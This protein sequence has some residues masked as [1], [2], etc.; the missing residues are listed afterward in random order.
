MAGEY[1]INLSN[2]SVL[3]TLYPL[4]TNGPD[5]RSTPRFIQQT[6]PAF[7]VTFLASGTG[8][9]LRDVITI[10]GIWDQ[11]FP[12]GV[13]FDISG[14]SVVGSPAVG[15]N[16]GTYA[17]VGVTTSSSPDQTHIE[18]SNGS[19]T[20][21]SPVDGNVVLNSFVLAGDVSYRF[22][23]GFQFDV[24]NS[25]PVVG[26]PLTGQ[27]DGTYTVDSFGSYVASNSTIIPVS[28]T[29]PGSGLPLGE[30]I[31][32]NVDTCS[33]LSLPGRGTLNYGEKVIE[34][35]VRLV[36]NFAANTPPNTN[37]NIGTNPSASPLVGQL[38]YNTTYGSEGFNVFTGTAWTSLNDIGTSSLV[39]NDPENSNADI[40]ITAAEA[41][42]PTGSPWAGT[43]EP[44]LV[45]WTETDPTDNTP[46]FRVLSSDGTERLR[47]E[48][49]STANAGYVST[50]NNLDVQGTG[51]SLIQGSLG[52]GGVTPGYTLDV[53]GT[54][55]IAGRVGI[56]QAPP[57]SGTPAG[58][59]IWLA[60]T[61]DIQANS[62]FLGSDGS[63]SDPTYSF[64]NEPTTG[65]FLDTGST[66]VF[67]VVGSNE[68]SISSSST[69][70]E[71]RVQVPSGSAVAPSMTFNNDTS[72]GT[73][74]A[75]S[76]TLAFA[77]GGSEALRINSNG[78][79]SVSLGSPTYDSFVTSDNDIPNKK[80]VD[81]TVSA[82]SSV[83]VNVT[84]DAMTGN[85]VMSSGGQFINPSAPT[86]SNDLTNKAYV[87][88]LVVSGTVWKAPINDPALV[89]FS[90]TEPVSPQTGAGYIATAAG[91]WTGSVAVV[92]GDYVYWDG[93]VWT[94][95]QNVT[96]GDRFIVAGESVVAENYL[97][98]LGFR[99][100]D[101]IEFT[102]TG[103][104]LTFDAYASWSFPSDAG[105]QVIDFG[106]AKVSGDATGLTTSS[107]Y[108][109][110]VSIAGTTYQISV[111]GANIA[112]YGGLATELT[113]QL[114]SAYAG[115]SV[116]LEAEGHFHVY[117]G[118]GSKVIVSAGTVGSP[119][120]DLLAALGL[121]ITNNVFGGIQD[122]TTI[123]DNDPESAHYGHTYVYTQRINTWTEIAGPG[124]IGAGTGLYYS[125]ATLNVNLGAGIQELPTD[126]VGID[127]H[128][129]GGLFTTLDGVTADTTANSQLGIKLDG[130]T[131]SLSVSGLKLST[132]GTA[133]TYTKVTTDAYGRVV[134]GTTLSASDLPPDGYAATYVNVS[135]DAMSGA[136]NMQ[137]H[138]IQSPELK[139][140]SVTHSTV[141]STAGAVTFDFSVS[142]SFDI[143]LTENVTSITLSNPPASGK[144]GEIVI[145]IIQ[146]ATG[147]WTVT[148]PV[149][150]KWPGGT[151][152][153]ITAAANS[154]DAIMLSTING[155]TTWRGNFQQNYS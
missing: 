63:V 130:S 138:V 135:G 116:V 27:N 23:P 147:G 97:G 11:Y 13:S 51:A 54:S 127:V 85:L 84:G 43:P 145:E 46:I 140:Y 124:S 66:L 16:D 134:S 100:S 128:T 6:K 107:T 65:M 126:E 95:V 146:D 149:N 106:T 1:D 42:L 70:F 71:H 12:V 88:S 112:T 62:Q 47:V 89:D 38:W 31:Y 53:L 136:L 80:Y 29:I 142:N 26:S 129:G 2:G 74:L 144:Y 82:L 34:N 48:H 67:S 72:T 101:L 90:A 102:D 105:Y 5:N 151:P 125:G 60:V 114:N 83:Y 36:E 131:L 22:I 86:N 153:T 143:T 99:K 141:S 118:D 25:A 117:S 87:D 24:Q 3:S 94:V 139:D 8:S 58:T 120:T 68:I 49:N 98:S 96:A 81:N 52:V 41:N 111:T 69:R 33:S 32:T 76:N 28:T 20:A 30:I 122:G 108:D 40:Y 19:L 50:V 119:A 93:A 9:P 35:F 113:T 55:H 59:D 45:I 21:V 56:N 154:I 121:T 103:S 37:P 10:D 7:A 115:A 104:P 57:V 44:G 79:L 73:F 132:A 137:D 78:L 4:E 123:F 75:A 17:V 91:T 92:A 133:G 150:V 155:G 61:G 18:V 64:T 152:P 15:Q 109:L 110:D 39:F 148:W 77:V 14:S